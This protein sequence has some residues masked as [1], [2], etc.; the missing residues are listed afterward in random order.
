MA[1]PPGK[2]LRSRGG[3][4]DKNGATSIQGTASSLLT[5]VRTARVWATLVQATAFEPVRQILES[6]WLLT[7]YYLLL[8]N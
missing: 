4:V 1:N 7:P 2:G 6:S 5:R 3:E 8:H